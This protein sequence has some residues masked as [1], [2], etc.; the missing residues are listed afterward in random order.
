[1]SQLGNY[2]KTSNRSGYIT[3]QSF[4][5]NWPEN[6]GSRRENGFATHQ[7]PS[8]SDF[9]LCLLETPVSYDHDSH[10]MNINHD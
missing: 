7:S 9:W 4:K 8:S 1:M 6:M 3:F 2:F 5:I 10:S